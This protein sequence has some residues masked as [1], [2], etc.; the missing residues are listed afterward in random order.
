MRVFFFPMTPLFP[1]DEMAHHQISGIQETHTHT[2]D[3]SENKKGDN[4]ITAASK[5]EDPKHLLKLY[6][7]SSWCQIIQMY[8]ITSGRIFS[9]FHS[10]KNSKILIIHRLCHTDNHQEVMH[11]LPWKKKLHAHTLAQRSVC[12]LAKAECV[13]TFIV[14]VSLLYQC[15]S[16]QSAFCFLLSLCIFIVK[17]LG[18]SVCR[19]EELK[20]DLCCSKLPDELQATV[21]VY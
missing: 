16:C 8:L 18:L 6:F 9:P 7:C 13:S 20:H 3:H 11:R 2:H 10:F 17:S 12:V 21:N 4:T 1:T 19:K 14:T 5:K 15:C